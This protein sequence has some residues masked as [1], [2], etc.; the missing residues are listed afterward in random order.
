MRI[1]IQLQAALGAGL[2]QHLLERQVLHQVERRVAVRA[3][4]VNVHV[5]RP[6]Y[7]AHLFIGQD[8]RQESQKAPQLAR[9]VA[10]HNLPPLV[11]QLGHLLRQLRRLQER[12]GK[13]VRAQ[14]DKRRAA[15]GAGSGASA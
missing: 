11:Q 3:L 2:E 9:T 7:V 14:R 8:K 15:A 6:Q 10:A 13:T 12:E 4:G 5:W 1:R